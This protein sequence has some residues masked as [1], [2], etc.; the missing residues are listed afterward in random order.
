MSRPTIP[1]IVTGLLGAIRAENCK[2]YDRA[3]FEAFYA[4]RRR[5]PKRYADLDTPAAVN[6]AI[7]DVKA[8]AGILRQRAE[9]MLREATRLEALAD[10]AAQAITDARTGPNLRLRYTIDHCFDPGEDSPL[11][12][13]LPRYYGVTP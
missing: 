11:A 12:R 10:A 9:D 1:E 5:A 6:I 3:A 4:L 8:Q 13:S 2:A 7:G